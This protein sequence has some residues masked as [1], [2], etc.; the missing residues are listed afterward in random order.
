M[1]TPRRPTSCQRRMDMAWSKEVEHMGF[2]IRLFERNG[3]IYRDVTLGRVVSTSG[4]AR[5]AH[6][7]KSLGHADRKLAEKQAKALAESL[8]EARL[9]GRTTGKITLG[10]LFVSYRQHAATNLSLSLQKEAEARSQMFCE[11]WGRDM[12]VADI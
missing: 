11:A 4:K 9:T 2:R 1:L 12:D 10:Q 7:K 5:T 6:D 3:M 8:A